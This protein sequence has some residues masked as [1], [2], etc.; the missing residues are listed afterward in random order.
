LGRVLYKICMFI[1]MITNS[2]Y[3]QGILLVSWICY[4][5]VLLYFKTTEFYPSGKANLES[6][7]SF[8]PFCVEDPFYFIFMF[9]A[10]EAFISYWVFLIKRPDFISFILIS[11]VSL[12][13]SAAEVCI[14]L[15]KIK[16]FDAK[17][18]NNRITLRKLF[19]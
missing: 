4:N 17:L 16:W 15:V 19:I 14:F 9:I 5:H 3:S 10:F 2:R 12:W 18:I 7:N 1:L 13:P 6:Q 8:F 11:I